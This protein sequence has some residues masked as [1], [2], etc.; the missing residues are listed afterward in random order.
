MAGFGVIE[1]GKKA[2]YHHAFGPD[3]GEDLEG[4]LVT[5]VTYEAHVQRYYIR[6]DDQPYEGWVFAE[7]VEEVGE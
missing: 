3:Y 2:R 6:F 7:E 4:A 5:V 1:S